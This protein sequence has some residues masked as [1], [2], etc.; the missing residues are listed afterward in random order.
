GRMIPGLEDGLVGA[1]AGEERVLNL[2]LPEAYQNLELAGKTAEFTVTV[3]T[4]SAPTL[5]ELNEK[6][7]KQFGIKETNLEGFRT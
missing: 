3:N 2:T 4:V 5:H 1:T 7:F 6:F